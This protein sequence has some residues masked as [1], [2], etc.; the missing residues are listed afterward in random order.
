[1]TLWYYQIPPKVVW[2]VFHGLM[3]TFPEQK[4][5]DHNYKNKS[6]LFFS[7]QCIIAKTT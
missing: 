4:Q 7:V 6:L 3:E 5:K 1:M 2:K